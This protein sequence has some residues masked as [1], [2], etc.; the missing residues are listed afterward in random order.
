MGI[1]NVTPDSFSDGGRHYTV[2]AAIDH[3]LRLEDQ[4]ADIIDIGGESTRP[5]APPLA[6]DVERARVIPV[7]EGLSGRLS[8]PISI[9]SYKAEVAAAA[10]AAG[11]EIVNDVSAFTFDENIAAVVAASSAGA[12]LM[13]TRGRPDVM[14][15][16]TEYGSLVDEVMDALACSLDRA[17]AA[18][19]QP[20]KLVLDPGI[21]FGKSVKGNLELLRR[22]GELTSLG[23]PLLVGTSRKAFIGKVTGREVGE[24]LFGT[25][26]TVAVALVNGASILRVH[27]V[28]AMRDV[29]DMTWAILH[30]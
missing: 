1:L 15:Q 14:Q 6:A 17:N 24:R 3:A 5:G 26:A 27:D 12:V 10:L 25:A 11:A 28:A 21:G 20:E 29:A 2:R 4:G 16:N 22:L 13:H 7:I 9:D 30:S 23:R 8:L 18:G 19:I